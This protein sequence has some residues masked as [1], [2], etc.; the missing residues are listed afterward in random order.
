MLKYCESKHFWISS[1]R[2]FHSKAAE[3]R[4]R[5]KH[6]PIAVRLRRLS[7]DDL[8]TRQRESGESTDMNSTAPTA[9]RH[10]RPPGSGPWALTLQP[11]PLDFKR[12]KG[13]A[14]GGV[15]RVA[16]EARPGRKQERVLCTQ[17]HFDNGRLGKGVRHR[18]EML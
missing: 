7:C 10:H 6:A 15:C 4:A 16:L 18:T 5:P 14:G 2:H 17:T 9:P 11:Q 3:G 13:R 8:R 12:R 1:F